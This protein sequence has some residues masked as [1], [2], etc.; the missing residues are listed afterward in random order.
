[1][2]APRYSEVLKEKALLRGYVYDESRLK[3][4]LVFILCLQESI[5]FSMKTNWGTQKDAIQDAL[6][7]VYVSMVSAG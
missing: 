6:S 5:C 3:R 1:M 2:S 7:D 4:L